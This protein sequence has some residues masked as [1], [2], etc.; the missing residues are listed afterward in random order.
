[1]SGSEKK[2][3]R[4]L[5]T[6]PPLK[7]YLR[8]FWKFHFVVVQN[9]GKEM[10]KK[11][12]KLLLCWLDLFLFFTVLR[13]CRRRLVL[14]DFIF[15]LRNCNCRDQECVRRTWTTCKIRHHDFTTF[16]ARIRNVKCKNVNVK[17]KNVLTSIITCLILQVVQVILY[18]QTIN[19]I[20]NFAFSPG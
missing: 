15:C 16:D 9:N 17:I 14:H 6:F 3:T 11:I 12:V 20:E 10:S 18:E 1:M 8:S 4:T 19:I 7:V 13:R 2:W 5:T